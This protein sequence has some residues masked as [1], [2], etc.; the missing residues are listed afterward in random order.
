VPEAHSYPQGLTPLVYNGIIRYARVK[1]WYILY[2]IFTLIY[3]KIPKDTKMYHK[4]HLSLSDEEYQEVVV[5]AKKEKRTVPAQ[6]RWLLSKAMSPSPAPAS[7]VP[8]AN[9]PKGNL[10]TYA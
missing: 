1:Y 4:V 3:Q 2:H 10:N 9:M 6:I 5:L 7:K 8:G